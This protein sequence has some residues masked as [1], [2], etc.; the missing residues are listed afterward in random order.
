MG[1]PRGGAWHQRALACA[2]LFHQPRHKGM[3]PAILAAGGELAKSDFE[4]HG[5]NETGEAT[6]AAA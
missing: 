5:V 1:G 3:R 4:V 6:A 2:A